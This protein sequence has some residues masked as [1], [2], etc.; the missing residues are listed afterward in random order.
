MSINSDV[1]AQSIP[2][3][4][5]A[6]SQE[7]LNK[8]FRSRGLVGDA[9]LLDWFRL[10]VLSAP[11]RLAVVDRRETSFTFSQLDE[12]SARVAQYLVNAGVKPRDVVGV[13]L[14]NWAEFTVF[15]VAC[16]KVGA[17]INPLSSNL[18]L[19]ELTYICNLAETKVTVHST[20]ASS[21]SCGEIDRGLRGSVPTLT[22]T[23][24]VEAEGYPCGGLTT[25]AQVIAATEP[26]P[27]DAEHHAHGDDLAAI[28][29]TSGSESQPKGVML[30]HNNLIAS[31]RSFAK[32]LSITIS[33]T[34]FMPA[35]VGHA[36]GFMHGVTMPLIHQI[37]SVLC[38]ATDG[39]T[40]VDLLEKTKATGGMAVPAVADSIVTECETTGRTLPHIRFFCCGG[41][42]VPRKLISRSMEYGMR[43]FS[44]YG[45]TESAPHTMTSC[46]DELEKV[47]TTDGRACP[48][49][50]IKIVDP[51]TREPVPPGTEGEEASRGP[52]VFMGYLKRPDLTAQVKDEAGWYYSGDIAVMDDEEYIRITGR[53]KDI[54]IR[55]GENISVAEVEQILIEHPKV[56]EAACIGVVDPSAGE[57]LLAC[58]ASV[59]GNE[60]TVAELQQYFVDHGVAKFKIP[61]YI[62]MLDEI[63]RL[64]SGKV[65]KGELRERYEHAFENSVPEHVKESC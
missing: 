15:Y 58:I 33:D 54:V 62:I 40:M 9:S 11:D 47:A 38:D 30:S 35:P 5:L 17:V 45:S 63:P 59:D 60:I 51:E 55:G 39:P 21:A 3:N 25:Y 28:L 18:R 61:E 43:L 64:Y 37:T 8:I 1:G 48:G 49:T 41:S 2:A 26:L 42:P 19:H 29:F 7:E 4:F 20:R 65:A 56:R 32:P 12:A 22:H 27:A 14:P 44:V 36:T 31:E 53:L 16:L 57:R 50:E 24:F 34:M 46:S 6:T 52:A 10:S 23:I 13:H